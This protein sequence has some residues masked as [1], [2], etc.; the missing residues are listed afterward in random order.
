MQLRCMVA[1]P[2]A[3]TVVEKMD[4]VPSVSIE[5]VCLAAAAKDGLWSH[6]NLCGGGLLVHVKAAVP[7][8]GAECK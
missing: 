3:C 5:C 8:I 6:L 2:S 4:R 1:L 7:F